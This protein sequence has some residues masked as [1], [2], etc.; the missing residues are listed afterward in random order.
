MSLRWG[1]L[2]LFMARVAFPAQDPTF[3][4]GVQ[5]VQVNVVAQDKQGKP[6][7]DLRREEFQL[8]DNGS[9]QEIRLFVAE[10]EQS[11]PALPEQMAANTFTNRIASP[12]G[13]HSGYSVILIDNLLTIFGDPT[14]EDGSANV[15]LQALRMLR[16][17][18]V[19][20]RIAI[21][22]LRRKLQVICE[23]T[24]DRNALERQ[25]QA[26]T[27]SADP[28][29]VDGSILG[30]GTQKGDASPG[31]AAEFGR[32]DTL[33]RATALNGNME[34]VADHLAGIPGRKNL[35]WLAD[36]FGISPRALQKLKDANVGV[37][38]VDAAG[39]KG[40]WS[41][42]E[43]MRVIAEQTGGIAY[44]G[45]NDLYVAIREAIDDGRIS[46]T[47]GFYASADDRQTQ[48]H[49]LSVHVNRPG[50]TLRY[51][52]SYQKEAIRAASETTGAGL[53]KA[54]SRPIDATA[55]PIQASVTRT[56]DRLNLQATLDVASLDLAPDRNLWKG[57]IEMAARFTTADGVVVGDV[58]SKTLVLNL[59]QATYDAAMRGGLPFQNEFM[60]PPKAVEL[61]LLFA[62]VA[63]GKIG[64][65]TIPVP[66]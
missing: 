42:R 55:I 31:V 2:A 65:L 16:S 11:N 23:F 63:A 1:G 30:D 8:F 58:F 59:R 41:R 24:S 54:L 46:Y 25:L 9:P 57:N 48:V 21:Y 50:V 27:P 6:V 52:T 38:P 44:F 60:I 14:K 19:G 49:Q 26:W 61:K 39:V 28:E 13:S 18:P 47:L 37:Y 29:G 20:E 4:T 36:Y 32:I 34:L 3:Q 5:L 35:I 40:P 62:N 64:T 15:R 43:P 51:R 10:T 7:A 45:R 53:A 66:N 12:T 17:I 56:K 33:Q 22:A